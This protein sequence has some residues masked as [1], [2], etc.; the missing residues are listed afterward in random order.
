MK[1]KERNMKKHYSKPVI[2][3][4]IL[5][6]MKVVCLSRDMGEYSNGTGET[7]LQEENAVTPAMSRVFWEDEE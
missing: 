6:P 2:G 1:N 4:V 5:E 7:E 3:E